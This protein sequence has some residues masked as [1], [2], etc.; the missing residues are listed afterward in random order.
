MWTW[1]KFFKNTYLTFIS[2]YDKF[3]CVF[4]NF[5]YLHYKIT[6]KYVICLRSPPPH[7]PVKLSGSAHAMY[8]K[9]YI[10]LNLTSLYPSADRIMM[11]KETT[12][13]ASTNTMQALWTWGSIINELI[14]NVHVST[15]CLTIITVRNNQRS[16]M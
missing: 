5:I 8:N 1:V 3:Y 9:H 16:I 10:M 6:K 15:F 7:P 11:K 14:H 12:V 4:L 13:N 2:L